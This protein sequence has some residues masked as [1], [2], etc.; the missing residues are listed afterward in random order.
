M[1][2]ARMSH[3]ATVLPSGSVLVSSGIGSVPLLTNEVYN[4]AQSSWTLAGQIPA[5]VYM[6]G[7][8]L[9]PNNQVLL[10]G[11]YSYQPVATAELYSATQN[12]VFSANPMPSAARN[13]TSTLMANGSVFAIGLDDTY[14][15]SNYYVQIYKPAP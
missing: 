6:Q 3:T 8:T 4:P 15:N 13:L 7:S 1:L 14:P 5:A 2:W 11:G 12:T 9:M 10:A